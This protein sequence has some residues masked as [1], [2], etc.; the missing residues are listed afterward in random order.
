ME[1]AIEETLD[2]R[3]EDLDWYV[4]IPFFLFLLLFLCIPNIP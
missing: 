1:G 2:A 4:V 3:W